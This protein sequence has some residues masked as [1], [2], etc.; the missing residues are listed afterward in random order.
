[1]RARTGAAVVDAASVLTIVSAIMGAA[2]K[3]A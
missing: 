2:R 1:M 3:S